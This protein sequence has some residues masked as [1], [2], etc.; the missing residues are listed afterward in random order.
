MV[1]VLAVSPLKRIEP[2]FTETASCSSRE[3]EDFTVFLMELLIKF[4]LLY[5]TALKTAQGMV[6][7]PSFSQSLP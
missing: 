7:L 4:L 5:L 1:L 2:V 3:E 6:F